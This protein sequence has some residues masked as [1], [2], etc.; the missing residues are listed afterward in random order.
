[1]DSRSLSPKTT[2]DYSKS[3]YYQSLLAFKKKPSRPAVKPPVLKESPI[4]Q[5]TIS[6]RKR[7]EE[8]LA[9]MELR[10]LKMKRREEQAALKL[11]TTKSKAEL[12]TAT[13][14]QFE[15]VTAR[16]L[17]AAKQ[18]KREETMQALMQKRHEILAKRL[19]QT[20]KMTT[21]RS[22]LLENKRVGTTQKRALELKENRISAINEMQ[23]RHLSNR[24]E[25]IKAKETQTITKIMHAPHARALSQGEDQQLLEEAAKLREAKDKVRARAD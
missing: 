12:F 8:I 17:E 5:Q 13:R 16:Q 21:T 1:M 6:D 19:A 2:F 9:S 23:E 3:P 22:E 10:V 24:L 4:L 7:T 15:E 14:L 25:R 11:S 18:R 20:Q